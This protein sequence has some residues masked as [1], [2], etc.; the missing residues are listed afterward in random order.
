MNIYKKLNFEK[1]KNLIGII[2][3]WIAK[4]KYSTT[5]QSTI[6]TFR[7]ISYTFFDQMWKYES[8]AT[9][10]KMKV[11]LLTPA[12]GPYFGIFSSCLTTL[13]IDLNVHFGPQS[14]ISGIS[15]LFGKNQQLWKCTKN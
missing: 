11:K 15:A 6:H 7:N 10:R 1:T 5:Y 9:F 8:S 3:A 12:W 13:T 14:G 4:D 2:F